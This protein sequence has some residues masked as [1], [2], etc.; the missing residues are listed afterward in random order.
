MK[1]FFTALTFLTI[2]KIE[3]KE[4]DTKNAVF[5]FPIIGLLIA[6]PVYFILKNNL[7]FKELLAIIYLI[8]ITGGL[9]LD[10]LADTADAFFSHRDREKKLEI[11]KDSRIGAMGAI[12][13]F[14]VI[15]IKYELLKMIKPSLVF[16]PFAYSRLGSVFLMNFLPYAR[17]K[18]TG[19]FFSK[20]TLKS[21]YL[22]LLFSPIFLAFLFGYPIL[23][24]MNL[25][26]LILLIIFSHL[27]KKVIGGWTGDMVGAF[28]EISETTFMYILIEF[29]LYY[30]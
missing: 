23:F 28:I 11:M 18:G 8:F 2:F 30:C 22:P 14:L 20:F 19:A 9:H 3:F 10:G 24:L 17:E 13:L 12:V 27:Y 4:Y 29:S 6:T 25:S 7:H 5:F 15:L 26:L 21:I 1:A 16:F